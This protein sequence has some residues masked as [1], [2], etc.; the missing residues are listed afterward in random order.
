MMSFE[1]VVEKLKDSY[2]IKFSVIQDGYVRSEMEIR[3]EYINPLGIVYGSMLYHL[4]DVSSGVAFMSAGGSGPTAS[5]DMQF[6]SSTEHA[7]KLFCEARVLKSGRKLFYLQADILDQ[8]DE[9]LAR[10]SYIFYNKKK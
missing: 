3:P 5:G 4:A 7:E 2:G 6:I 8:T 1:E 9:L 10:G